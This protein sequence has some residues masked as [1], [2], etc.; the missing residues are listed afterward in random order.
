M[1]PRKAKQ[2]KQ[3]EKPVEQPP[4]NPKPIMIGLFGLLHS[5]KT[6]ILNQLRASLGEIHFA[7]YEVSERISSVVSDGFPAFRK[8][9]E[10][11]KDKWREVVVQQIRQECVISGK[12]SIVT[13]IAMTWDA[14]HHNSTLV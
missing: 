8:M 4:I 12:T 1:A 5:G 13:N 14:L 9:P 2:G 11:E 10:Q 6:G 7:F 3:A